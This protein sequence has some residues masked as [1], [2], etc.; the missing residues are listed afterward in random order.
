MEEANTG[1]CGGNCTHGE[2]DG[3][4]DW[5]VG[6]DAFIH[7]WCADCRETLGVNAVTCERCRRFCMGEKAGEV[8]T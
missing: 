6:S 8:E 1:L 2:C 3:C 5:H 7:E 4:D